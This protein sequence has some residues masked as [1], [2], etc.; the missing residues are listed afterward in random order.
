MHKLMQ[1]DPHLVFQE[2]QVV[3]TEDVEMRFN[4]QTTPR[5]PDRDPWVGEEFGTQ[6]GDRLASPDI[7]RYVGVVGAKAIRVDPDAG[8]R[9]IRRLPFR[10][11]AEQRWGPSRESLV[12]DRRDRRAIRYAL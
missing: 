12:G 1:Q 7:R 11:R 2:F 10:C 8:S 9:D 4:G 3:I 6:D 5:T